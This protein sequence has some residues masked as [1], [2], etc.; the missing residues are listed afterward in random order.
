MKRILTI[1]VILLF[2]GMSISSS[3]GFNFIEQ[4]NTAISNGKTLYVGGSGPNNYTKIQ[5]AIDNASD[6]DTVFVYNRTYYE[7]LMLDK[8]IALT[9]ENQNTTI[10]DGSNNKNS[11]VIK[12]DADWVNISG[13]TIKYGYLAGIEFEV[14]ANHN[15]IL[16]NKICYNRE[17]GIRLYASDYT[18]IA[19]NTIVNNNDDGI[20]L[21]STYRNTI[22]GNIIHSNNDGGIDFYFSHYNNIAG[23]NISTNDYGIF[24]EGSCNN[25]VTSNAISCNDYGVYLRFL[26]DWFPTIIYTIQSRK[27]TIIQNNFLDNKRQAF[28]AGDWSNTWIDNYWNS[29]RSLPKI[30]IGVLCLSESFSIMPLLIPWFNIDWHPAQEPYDIEV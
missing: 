16:S 4:S 1:G 28:C 17:D 29:P 24:I 8:S 15:T 21:M 3:T 9:G 14:Y 2:I 26:F 6:G 30:I 25:N 22:T 12:I 23:N 18:T 11:S 7:N 20:N 27:N 5:D 10:I 13:F 19:S